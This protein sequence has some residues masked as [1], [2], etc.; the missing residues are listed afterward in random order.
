MTEI[1]L[2]PNTTIKFSWNKQ[3]FIFIMKELTSDTYWD[4]QQQC[5]RYIDD[6]VKIDVPKQNKLFLASSIVDPPQTIE[7]IAALPHP[8][9]QILI[10][11]FNKIH[12]VDEET[13]K[14]TTVT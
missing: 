5:T 8:I 3:E 12:L 13:I 11:A 14:K 9:T 1:K 10:N 2:R 4:I 6:Q 7:T